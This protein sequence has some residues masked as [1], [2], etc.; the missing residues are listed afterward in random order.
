MG[1]VMR[2]VQTR[3]GDPGPDAGHS[4]LQ[5][6]L[7]RDASLARHDPP[8]DALGLRTAPLVPEIRLFLAEDPVLLWAR[9]EADAETRL[10][11]PYWAT[12]WLGGLALAR[13]VLDHPAAVA[14]RRV[15]DVASGSGLVAIA[16]VLAGAAEVT[17]NDIDPYAIAAIR[18][19]AAA[20]GV[21]LRP[22]DRDRTG[23]AGEDADV[24]LIG[25]GVYSADVAARMLPFV[26]RASAAGRTVLIGEPGRGHAPERHFETLA[27]Y[28]SP[29][30][31]AAEYGQ[32]RQTSV[33][34]PAA[35][36]PAR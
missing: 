1:P 32:L 34:T 19:N 33:L 20:N 36:V 10:G 22:D 30:L 24:V 15:L 5:R 27:T 29:A 35:P 2:I 31:A 17:A 23:G 9:L 25:D 3:S 28:D 18:A 21:R 4:A 16:A 14:G 11:A 8:S 7:F 13:Y 6:R 12:A 26:A